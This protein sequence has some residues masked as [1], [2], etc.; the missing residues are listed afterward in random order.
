[1]GAHIAGVQCQVARNEGGLSLR[2]SSAAD[3]LDAKGKPRSAKSIS[4]VQTEADESAFG[5]REDKILGC[6]EQRAA[7][8][9]NVAYLAPV[10]A[11]VRPPLPRERRLRGA[12]GRAWS[13]QQHAMQQRLGSMLVTDA[14]AAARADL[15]RAARSSIADQT[16]VGYR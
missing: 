9:A 11:E 12:H 2:V 16:R 15:E 6:R 13:L 10:F 4:P 7:W 1:M 3:I 5:T 14:E 8:D